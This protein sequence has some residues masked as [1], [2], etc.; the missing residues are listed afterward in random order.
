MSKHYRTD[1]AM[2]D[3]L[4]AKVVKTRNLCSGLTNLRQLFFGLYDLHL[5]TR[6]VEEATALNCNLLWSQMR[7]EI[8]LV[9]HTPDT[10]PAAGFAHIGSGGYASAYYGYMWALVY[11]SDVFSRFLDAGDIFSPAIGAEL[12]HKVLQWGG[13]QDELQMTRDFLQ[14]EPNDTAFLQNIGVLRNSQ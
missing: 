1:E 3:D 5:H 13:E 4:I 7:S 11:A 12:R 8:T 14:R 10:S 6:S 2:P 9:R